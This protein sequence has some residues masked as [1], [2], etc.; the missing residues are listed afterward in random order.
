[1]QDVPA[2]L[3]LEF[4]R[5]D[6]RHPRLRPGERL[7]LSFNRVAWPGD[8]VLIHRDGRYVLA[9][10]PTVEPVIAIVRVR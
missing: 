8:I 5:R 7:L 6:V 3:P 10:A 9:I 2:D 4:R 1:M